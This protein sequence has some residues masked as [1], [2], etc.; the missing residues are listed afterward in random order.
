MN[1]EFDRGGADTQLR[2]VDCHLPTAPAGKYMAKAEN[3]HH[4]PKVRSE[5]PRPSGSKN[6]S[7]L[8]RTAFGAR[9]DRAALVASATSVKG[10]VTCVL[11]HP[12]GH[13][14][15]MELEAGAGG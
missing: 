6:A 10:D 3:S 11:P 5:L 8:Q 15:V 9:R 2:Q 13:G 12:A 7:I 1:D 14:L 4:P